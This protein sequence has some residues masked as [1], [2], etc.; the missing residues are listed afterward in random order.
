[1][2]KLSYDIVTAADKPDLVSLVT[3]VTAK[4]W[5]EFMLHDPVAQLF[6]TVYERLPQFQFAFLEPASDNIIVLGNSIP[7]AY[8]GD[9]PDLPD[10]G[11]DWAME[12]GVKDHSEGRKA[13]VLCALQIVV[14]NEYL[15]HGLSRRAVETMKDIGRAHKL[16]SLVAPVRPNFKANHP[17]V[18]MEEYI[19]WKDDRGL[20][21]DPWIRV[22]VRS[23]GRII[24]VCHRAMRITGT[25]AD[26]QKWTGLKIAQSSKQII[27]GALVPVEFDLEADLG[28]YIEPNVWMHHPL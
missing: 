6:V 11:W 4:A 8:D 2:V 12:S 21:F 15:G 16:K 3:G 17:L 1:M 5:P 24:K 19:Q 25:I 28:T 7:L 10:T 26:W 14:A 13:S 18:P 27:P 22:H 20:P 23:G 9:L